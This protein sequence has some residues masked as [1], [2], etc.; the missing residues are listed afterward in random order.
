MYAKVMQRWILISNCINIL[1]SKK[2]K[3]FNASNLK[4]L[5]LSLVMFLTV[6]TYG[7]SVVV[8]LNKDDSKD[9]RSDIHN[10]DCYKIQLKNKSTKVVGL[11]GQNYRLYYN[12]E[13]VMMDESSIQNFLPKSYT[14]LNLVQHAFDV[15]ATGFGVLPFES[16]LGFINLATDYKLSSGMPVMIGVGET[17]DVARMCFDITDVSK[18]AALTWAKEDLTQT[19][20]TA[21]VEIASVQGNRLKKIQIDDLVVT[22]TRTTSLHDECATTLEFFPNPF[23]DVLEIK[24]SHP[25]NQVSQ[26]EMYDVSGRLI[27]SQA[28][29]AGTDNIKIDGKT[30]HPGAVMVKISSNGQEVVTSKVIRI[31]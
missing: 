3:I 15:N 26:L 25:F 12:S 23:K 17:M 9:Q 4:F 7:Q 14:V 29:E 13:A 6:F 2:M 5:M 20:A 24:L 27:I 31:E 30:I 11:A 16:H 8:V 19:Y 18:D 22:G 28:I 21:F 1:K 10:Q